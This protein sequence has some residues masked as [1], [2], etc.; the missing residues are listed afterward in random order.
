M[1]ELTIGAPDADALVKHVTGGATELCAVLYTSQYTRSDGLMRLLVRE[2][3]FPNS[4]DYTRIGKLEA[5]LKPEFVA[6]VSKRA[7][8]ENSGLVFVHSHPGSHPPRFSAIDDDGEER[9]AAF[10]SHRNPKNT[11]LALVVSSGGMNCRRLGAG[12][13]VRIVLLGNDREEFGESKQNTLSLNEEYDRQVRAFGPEGQRSLEKLRV[14]IVGLGGTGSIIAQQLVHLGVKDLMLIDHDVIDPTNLNRVANATSQDVGKSKLE[15]ASRYLRAVNSKAHI[16]CIIGNIT[17]AKHAQRL[18]DA[19][20]IFGCTDSHGSR[21]VLQQ[22]AYQYLIPYIDVGSTIVVQDGK[23]SYVIGR[24][25][26]LAPGIAC[27]ACG[28]LLDS[29]EVRRDMMSE[30]ERRLDPYLQGVREPAPAV[31]SIN[32]TVASLGV[33]MFLSHVAHIPA[34]GRHLFYDALNSKLRSVIIEPLEDCYNC[35]KAGGYARG[36]AAPLNARLD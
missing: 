21:A 5:E 9:L 18:L 10:L 11:H 16:E 1:I 29:N 19:D 32:G 12:E 25:Q 24:A 14:A 27:F 7:R 4:R 22:I 6:H 33:T 3:Q 23:I 26:L 2:V 13:P 17:Y 31:M 36:A 15:V 34:P 28:N 30:S 35:S 20:L 8:L